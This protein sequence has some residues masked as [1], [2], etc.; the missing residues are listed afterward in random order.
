MKQVHTKHNSSPYNTSIGRTIL[1]FLG[2]ICLAYFVYMLCR[3]VFV[4]ENWHLYHNTLFDNT[5]SSLFYG[6]L[7]FDTSAIMYTLAL[8][9]LLMLFP[10]HYKESHA[11]Q[12]AAKYVFLVINSIAITLNLTDAVYFQFVGHRTTMSVFNE[13]QN[14]NNLSKIFLNGCVQHWYLVLA[15][16]LL[17]ILMLKLYVRPSGSLS[18]KNKYTKYYT[19]HI[20]AFL[21]FAPFCVF[22]MRGGFTKATRPIT[23]SNANMYVNTPSDASAILN[24]P[25]TLIRTIGKQSYKEL[26][27][28]SEEE[29]DK[30][31]S[32]VHCPDTT[33]S[34]MTKKNVVILILESF[35]REY[36]GIYNPHLDNGQYKG[37]TPFL[38]KLFA[39]STTFE[40]TFSNGRK[41]IDGMP[42]IL[43][44]IPMMV[45]PYFLSQ[46]SMN[47]VS[48]LAGELKKVGYSSAFFH[49][50]HNSSM[51][52]HAFARTTG[53]E[54][55]FGRSEFDEDQRFGG[56]K[57]FDGTWAIWDEP[58]L[59]YYA[60]K[61]TDMKEPFITSVFTASSHHPFAVP[62][63]YKD[64]YNDE[65]NEIHKCIRYSDHALELFFETAKKQPWFDNTIFVLTCDHTNFADHPEY[66]TALGVFC[67]PLYIYDP[68]HIIFTA[69]CRPGIAQ[70]I[71]IMPTILNALGYN[72]P[73][74]AFGK[75]LMN[76]PSNETWAVNYEGMFQFVKGDYFMQYD[77]EQ[78][79]GLYNFKQDVLLKNNLVGTKPNEEEELKKNLQ[80]IIQSYTYR[81]NHDELVIK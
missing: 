64:I 72:K 46:R 39:E 48:G 29:L 9:A 28:F 81:M 79:I 65:G 43:S 73:Y 58:F 20:L 17:I 75:D 61:M 15:G 36:F 68:T 6:S 55:Y 7:L 59:Q 40:H 14:E 62:E 56:E 3:V 42:S 53:F 32:P 51:G 76:T 52:F 22:G 1:A 54:S 69:E 80:A 18:L 27:Y 26:H 37:Y 77:G 71:D 66:Q 11:W 30:I 31:Y 19:L 35:G 12:N 21:T 34:D 57:E 25:F 47:K 74:I 49:G 50:A 4:Y 38:D 24:T 23:L 5:T 2:N 70:Q 41:S 33:R 8:Y 78:V 16:I 60:H 63:K 45:V 67:A 44:S 10:I 13:F